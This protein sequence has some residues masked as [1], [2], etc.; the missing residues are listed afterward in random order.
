MSADIIPFGRRPQ[1]PDEVLNAAAHLA[2]P[3]RTDALR[4]HV[5]NAMSLAV[6]LGGPREWTE[7]AIVHLKE[8]S[9]GRASGG[10]DVSVAALHLVL[11]YVEHLEGRLG[12]IPAP[13]GAA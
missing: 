12:I 3:A 10:A 8:Q 11:G 9:S 7:S 6:D 4:R 13:G 5:A 1:T 2:E